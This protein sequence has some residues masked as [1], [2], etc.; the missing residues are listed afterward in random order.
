MIKV[1]FRKKTLLGYI[2]PR[3]LAF[4]TPV[5]LFRTLTDLRGIVLSVG[6]CG[7]LWR[8]L[9]GGLDYRQTLAP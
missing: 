9:E 5:S 1:H 3:T 2:T 8:L 7:K 4:N 6:N